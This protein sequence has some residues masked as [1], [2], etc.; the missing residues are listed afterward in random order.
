MKT[1][2]VTWEVNHVAAILNDIE[3]QF[4]VRFS[5]RVYDPNEVSLHM[6]HIRMDADGAIYNFCFY[7]AH[8]N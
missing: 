4:M 1:P 2:N 5:A 6:Q 8:S 3:A 7:W